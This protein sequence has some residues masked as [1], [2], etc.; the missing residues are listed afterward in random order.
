[1]RI[2]MQ[3]NF[4]SNNHFTGNPRRSFFYV[5]IAAFLAILSYIPAIP[6]LI[7]AHV[8]VPYSTNTLILLQITVF[9]ISATIFS[10]AGAFL[11]PQ[12]GFR[13]YLADASIAENT[14]WRVLKRQFLY[15]ASTGLVGAIVA[16]FM[17]P[18]FI[19][20]LSMVPLLTRLVGGVF[21]EVIMRWGLLTIIIWTL[22]RIFQR[23][24][25]IPKELLI[26]VCIF[27]SQ[28]LF[29]FAHAPAL[30][31]YGI[32]HPAW[33]I[34]TIFIVSLPWGWLFW[35]YGLESAYIAHASFH[36][37]VALFVAVK[38]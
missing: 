29:A 15:G 21:E 36:G 11:A 3:K 31:N 2:D 5:W 19:S 6:K 28:I 26:Y 24:I 4:E 12:I 18:D 20:Y 33:S 13:A 38:L 23:G 16:Y 32:T 9:L 37:F 22:W 27:L 30:V 34:F 7:P 14:F 35:K 1:M 25:G 17:A 8:H 10:A